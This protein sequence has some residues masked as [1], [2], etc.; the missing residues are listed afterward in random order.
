MS[1]SIPNSKDKVYA[2]VKVMSAYVS[3]LTEIYVKVLPG[4]TRLMGVMTSKANRN[5][6]GRTAQE[7]GTSLPD[8]RGGRET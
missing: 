3:H 1:S 5:R 8:P 6:T 7:N 4:V 2:K